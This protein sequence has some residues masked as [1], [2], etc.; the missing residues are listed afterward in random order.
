MTASVKLLNKLDNE[1]WSP[2][3]KVL[4]EQARE[5]HIDAL[6]TQAIHLLAQALERKRP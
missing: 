6:L 3:P 4:A 1:R 2:A 5:D